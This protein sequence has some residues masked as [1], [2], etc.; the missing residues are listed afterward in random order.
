ML[1]ALAALALLAV[2]QDVKR[3]DTFELVGDSGASAQQIILGTERKMLI[4]D[5]VQSEH[6]QVDGRPAWA[7]E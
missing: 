5:K 7:T 2:A 6:A 4:I 1:L 3:A